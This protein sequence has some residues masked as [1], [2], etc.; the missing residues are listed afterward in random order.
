MSGTAPR[1][2]VHSDLGIT[3]QI[4][5]CTNLSQGWWL[6]LTNVVVAQ[7]PY[8]FADVVAAAESQ[9]FYRVPVVGPTPSG[10]ALILAGSFTMG[11][12][13]DPAEGDDN[14]RRGFSLHEP[15]G[16]FWGERVWAV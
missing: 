10:M 6:A 16:V 12:C 9:R 2:G 1:F 5:S 3:N 8:W 4:Q 7:S 11:N 13:M 14:E 15:G